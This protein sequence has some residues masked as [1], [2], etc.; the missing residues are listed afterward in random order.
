MFKIY[1]KDGKKLH[2]W[3]AWENEAK[4]WIIH[5]GIA[6]KEGDHYEIKK[7]FFFSAKK[8][9]VSLLV[10]KKKEGFQEIPTEAQD[11]LMVEYKVDGFGDEKDLKKRHYIQELLDNALRWTGLG[12]C[13]GGS[14][15]HNTMEICCY[16]VDYEKAVPIVKKHLKDGYTNN[17][18]R[19]YNERA[20]SS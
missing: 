2:Y 1:K 17:Y 3:E 10:E 9:A 16:V 8:K 12:M 13:D 20:P 19:I 7:P 15:G 5:Y 18:T 14:V 6:G 11:I 4:S